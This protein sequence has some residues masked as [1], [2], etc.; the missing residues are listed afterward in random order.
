MELKDIAS[1]NGKGGLFKVVKPTRAGV[2]L[3]SI[4]NTKTKFIAGANHKVSLLK[5]I[6]IYTTTK[7]GSIPLE[8][9]F[10]KIK[11]EFGDGSLPINGKSNNNELNSFISKVIPDYDQDRVYTSDIKKLAAWYEIINKYA[12]EIL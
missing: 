3:E 9:V 2:I 7:E 5:E 12:S 10:K 11:N 1:V 8:D 4:D 6:S